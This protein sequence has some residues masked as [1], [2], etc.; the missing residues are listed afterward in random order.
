MKNIKILP[1][2]L[3]CVLCMSAC[4]SSSY[5]NYSSPVNSIAS[6]DSISF[7]GAS[8]QTSYSSKGDF[9]VESVAV[10]T[11]SEVETNNDATMSGAKLIRNVYIDMETTDLDKVVEEMKGRTSKYGGYIQ[12]IQVYNYTNS[13]DY[14]LDIRIPYAQVDTFLDGIEE[15][16]VISS[17]ND[18]TRDITL[19]YAGIETRLENL[20]TQHKRLLE[21]LEGAESLTD[22]ITLEERLSDVETELDTYSLEIKNYDNL[23]NYSTISMRISEYDYV[24]S[25]VDKSV[26]GRIK[27]GMSD[28]L[29]NIKEGFFDIVVWFVVHIPNI[30]I[31]VACIAIIVF[32]FKKIRKH[33]PKRKKKNKEE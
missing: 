26:I 29:H 8:A 23:I 12:N 30:I 13:R 17:I 33:F 4:G 32:V 14:N 7:S 9:N 21:L 28:N 22:I 3:I 6:Y 20:N 11:A 15:Y 5:D 16:G 18:S 1:V 10:D 24:S 25:H 19:T 31:A 27:S 2:I